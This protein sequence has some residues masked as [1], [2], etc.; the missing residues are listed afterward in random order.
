MNL[1]NEI[2]RMQELAG[3]TPEMHAFESYLLENKDKT[4]KELFSLLKEDIDNT[5]AEK[6]QDYVENMSDE[7][8]KQAAAVAK[9][10][11]RQPSVLNLTADQYGDKVANL[12]PSKEV[13]KTP[14]WKRITVGALALLLMANSLGITSKIANKIGGDKNRAEVEAQYNQTK[15][16]FDKKTTAHFSGDG[17]E[18][19]KAEKLN[20]TLDDP[21]DGNDVIHVQHDTGESNID[22]E[23]DNQLDQFADDVTSV[24]DKVDVKVNVTGN[25]SY[26]ADDEANSNK[27]NDGSQLDKSRAETVK[28]SLKDK[29]TDKAE[30]KGFDVTDN[31]D[32]LKL[33]KNGKT[34]IIKLTSDT[35]PEHGEDN[36]VGD[37][38]Q[39]SIVSVDLEEPDTTDVDNI[40][41]M[42]KLDMNPG[43]PRMIPD[44][45]D[46]V[47]N[48]SS[49][50]KTGTETGVER[51]RPIVVSKANNP[52]VQRVAD[53]L[54]NNTTLKTRFST[55]N[56]ETELE[57]LL[58]ALIG[59][60]NPTFQTSTGG[61]LVNRGLTSASNL[62]KE[63]NIPTDIQNIIK[64]INQDPALVKLLSNVNNEKEWT[65]LLVRVIV[66][67]LPPDFRQNKKAI[68]SAFF[69]ARNKW[70]KIFIEWEKQN[71]GKT[72]KEK[73]DSQPIEDPKTIQTQKSYS[74]WT[75]ST[76]GGTSNIIYTLKEIRRLQKLAGIKK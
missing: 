56:N 43:L 65:E 64:V 68:K 26:Q 21:K 59:T 63:A 62:I 55:I 71:K 76:T 25:Y 18:I 52:D 9:K 15:K 67:L 6:A 23:D 72:D 12:A 8:L 10:L 32:S 35:S 4:L 42:Q 31:G 3:V 44:N 16:E 45:P 39:S 54:K 66:P 70:M 47:P 46:D 17:D 27:A 41:K 74:P 22:D 37:V 36:E 75:T 49:T 40:L 58:L 61:S 51:E 48:V 5:T 50:E 20:P 57:T 24:A 38:D 7:E 53:K 69:R 11:K 30:A 34:H 33:T 73:A 60:V 28:A 19:D 2:K 1:L 13:A 14:L 29:F